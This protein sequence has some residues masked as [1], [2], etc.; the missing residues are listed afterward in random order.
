MAK[1][2]SI[3]GA[4]P[5]PALDHARTALPRK[6]PRKLPVIAFLPI[7]EEQFPAPPIR[8]KRIKTSAPRVMRTGERP[9]SLGSTMTREEQMHASLEV[10]K[11]EAEGA[12]FGPPATFEAC[13]KEKEPCVHYGCRH[14]AGIEVDSDILKLNFP[15]RDVDEMPETCTLRVANKGEG[16]K[17]N[18][19]EWRTVMSCE[20]V[21]VVLNLTSERVRQEERVALAKFK[22]RLLRLMPELVNE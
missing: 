8:S 19:A 12:K 10:W 6:P 1:Q 17:G 5:E 21:G 4:G 14:H 16:K 20:E 9:Q 7:L 13:L 2:L 15:D 3:V 22:R 11:L 18:A